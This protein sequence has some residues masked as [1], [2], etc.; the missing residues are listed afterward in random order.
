M[1]DQVVTDK[2]AA[3]RATSEA[4]HRDPVE[5]RQAA[6]FRKLWECGFADLIRADFYGLLALP[7]EATGN[8]LDAGCATGIEAANLRRLCHR[9]RGSKFATTGAGT[10]DTWCRHIIGD[11][12]QRSRE[13]GDG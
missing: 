12:G 9:D 1:P 3:Y 2:S 4:L 11:T 7:E 5:D 8:L 10:G 13:T 6:R